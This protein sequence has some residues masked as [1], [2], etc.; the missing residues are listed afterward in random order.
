M[1][2]ARDYLREDM[3]KRP[4]QLQREADEVRAD[5]EHTV[6]D[7]VNRLSPGELINQA[8][9][10]FRNSGD[11][12]FVRNLSNQVQNN[13]IPAI[14]AGVSL[15]WLMAASKRPPAA[16][17]GSGAS[18]GQTAR[19]ASEKLSSAK[20]SVAQSA[21]DK[22]QQL[23][24]TADGMKRRLGDASRHAMESTRSGAHAVQ[25][26][27]QDLLRE[28]PL[29][30]GALAIAA[31]AALGAMLPRTRAEDETMGEISDQQKESVKQ[32]AEKRAEEVKESAKSQSTTH[33]RVSGTQDSPAAGASGPPGSGASTD[34]AQTA[35]SAA[36]SPSGP[37]TPGANPSGLNS[38]EGEKR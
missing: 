17:T 8:M 37:S 14:L 16:A 9:A 33:S 18:P 22:Q 12:H 31:G 15:T 28:Q 25:D 27:Y 20:G 36:S 34:S 10:M 29:V 26:T 6:D 2:T 5:M 11:N 3:E 35:T 13:P 23:A 32:E 1:S 21:R 7:L 38:R 24:E 19:Q 4:E 30:I